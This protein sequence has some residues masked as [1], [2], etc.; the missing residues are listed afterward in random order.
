MVAGAAWRAPFV[1]HFPRKKPP[2]PPSP[3]I[4]LRRETFLARKFILCSKKLEARP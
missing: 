4:G 2:Q 1:C 3:A